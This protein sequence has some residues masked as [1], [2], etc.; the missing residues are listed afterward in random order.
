MPMQQSK[1]CFI[2]FSHSKSRLHLL[3][4]Y[5]LKHIY[6]YMYD[7]VTLMAFW[8]FAFWRGKYVIIYVLQKYVD[9][10]LSAIF[11]LHFYD[12][13]HVFSYW[14]Q[15]KKKLVYNFIHMNHNLWSEHILPNEQKWMKLPNDAY[16]YVCIIYACILSSK[17]C[18]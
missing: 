18:A 17:V 8:P 12:N 16:I 2:F 10:S 15:V 9:K 3:K 13:K 4:N 11:W 6:I 7:E 5:T 1:F 14:V